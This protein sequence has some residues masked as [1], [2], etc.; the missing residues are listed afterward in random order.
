VECPFPPDTCRD[1]GSSTG[2]I[3]CNTHYPVHVPIALYELQTKAPTKLYIILS[4]I[5]NLFQKVSK[6]KFRD[7]CENIMA[8][9]LAI[10]ASLGICLQVITKRP[11]FVVNME[12]PNRIL[13]TSREREKLRDFIPAERAEETHHLRSETAYNG[14]GKGIK[15]NNTEDRR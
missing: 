3:Y 5:L 12:R 13:E 15:G 7:I 14:S 10:L 6:A 1:Q 4:D 2:K 9:K 11:P 8:R